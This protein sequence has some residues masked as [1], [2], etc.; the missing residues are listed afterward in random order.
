MSIKKENNEPHK[1]RNYKVCLVD[2]S[3]INIKAIELLILVYFWEGK[4]DKFDLCKILGVS[5]P[6]LWRLTTAIRHG[7]ISFH[8]YSVNKGF[9]LARV[10][11]EID[12]LFYIYYSIT[13]RDNI[14]LS[15]SRNEVFNIIRVFLKN[16]IFLAEV[17]I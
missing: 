9:K 4:L 2:Q 14:M 7:G 13:F 11:L 15:R 16:K 8:S 6:S 10:N 17:F 12:Y 5:E 1:K 3:R